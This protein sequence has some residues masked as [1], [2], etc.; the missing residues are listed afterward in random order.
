MRYII[1]GLFLVLGVAEVYA[2]SG[3]RGVRSVDALQSLR[4]KEIEGKLTLKLDSLIEDNYNKHLVQSSKKTGVKGWRIRIFS[5]NGFGA[6]ENQKRVKA[7]FLS[8]FPEIST[9]DRYEGSYYKIYVGDFRTK[10]EAL[11]QLESI[12]KKFPDAF[13][14]EDNIIIEE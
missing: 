13:I 1:L 12:R 11:E 7:N 3:S 4:E 9:H 10:R 2:Q 6:K 8:L 14:V 5:D